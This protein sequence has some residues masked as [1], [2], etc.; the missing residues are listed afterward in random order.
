MTT[1]GLTQR[2]STVEDYEERRDCLDQRW[3]PLLESAGF[4]SVPLSNR[5]DDAGTIVSALGLEAVVLTGGNDLGGLPGATD[6]APERDTFERSLLGVA[7]D[8]ELPVLGVCR[9]AQLLNRHLGGEVRPVDGHVASPHPIAV[10]AAAL[11]A[12]PLAVIDD[13][14]RTNSYHGYGIDS[15]GLAEG[16]ATV[17]TAPD[18]TV[19]WFEHER[20][21]V[22]G[23]MW[24]PERDSPSPD[25][26]RWIVDHRLGEIR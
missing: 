5:I 6:V 13:P 4:V 8:R 11:D 3:A 23:V 9:G 18:G 26:D 19:E 16:L 10:D 14:M 21:P 7:L 25:L 1:V 22:T 17:G 12:D 20:L 15:D 24:H 2:V